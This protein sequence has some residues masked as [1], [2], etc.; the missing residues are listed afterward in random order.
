MPINFSSAITLATFISNYT[1]GKT[2]TITDLASG[3]LVATSN[4]QIPVHVLYKPIS[5]AIPSLTIWIYVD[6]VVFKFEGCRG[7][8]N[9]GVGAGG[10]GKILVRPSRA[11]STPRPT[12][13]FRWPRW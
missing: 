4:Y 11:G 6:G 13:R 2:A 5:S 9:L 12:P 3:A 8:F 7:T 1:V 10:A